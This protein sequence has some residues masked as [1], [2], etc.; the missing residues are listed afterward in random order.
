MSHMSQSK[1]EAIKLYA[2]PIP[3]VPE[4]NLNGWKGWS[5]L[6]D[7]YDGDTCTCMVE[8]CNHLFK[9]KVRLMGINT[10]E[11]RGGDVTE[12]YRAQVARDKLFTFL[13]GLECESKSKQDLQKM[14]AENMCLVWLEC[15]KCD[16]YGRTL[17]NIKRE[18]EGGS[19]SEFLVNGGYAKVF[20]V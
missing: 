5:R 9:I 12:K 16:K 8:F 11:I 7:V 13:T 15:G 6:V 4:L 1:F 14:L 20:M 19:A 2:V 18:K 17:A 10:P 3:G